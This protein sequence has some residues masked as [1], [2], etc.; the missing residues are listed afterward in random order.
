M[1]GKA[2]RPDT[3]PPTIPV[4]KPKFL[5]TR[6]TPRLRATWLGHACYLVEFPHG[7]RVLFDPVFTSRCSPFSWLGPKRYTEIP[8]RVEDI[9]IIDLAIISHN[10]YDHLSYETVIT[11][12]KKNPNTHFFVP[13]GNKAWFES[14]GIHNVTELD[15]WES[16]YVQL[17]FGDSPS[18]AHDEAEG[19]ASSVKSNVPEIAGTIHCTPS[20]HMSARSAFDRAR[21]LWAS[22][23]VES[24]GKRVWFAGDSG[25][26][27]VPE[28]LEGHDD[29]DA[30]YAD[31][32]RCPAFSQIG[33]HRG[34]F[35]L[36]LIPIGAYL[37]RWIMS[38]M[39]A[40]PFDSVDMFRD[41]GCKRALGMHWGTFVLTEED[42]LAP[43]KLLKAALKQSN[44]AEEGIFDICD[45][46]ETREF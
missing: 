34:P 37:P 20:Q 24:G 19:L 7:L 8:C 9:P 35:D 45:I 31:L 11:I 10:H 25:Y 27:A 16:R 12:K 1:T 30:E 26:R 43:P 29:Y 41:T 39:H 46:G 14:C 21:T 36:G 3:T 44:V 4:R 15:W 33:N 28:Q 22:W 5:S 38:P 6:D 13:L 23:C 32:P 42:V 40:N 17:V 18:S 2:N